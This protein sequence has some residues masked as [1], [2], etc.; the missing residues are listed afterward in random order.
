MNSEGIIDTNGTTFMFLVPSFFAAIF[1]AILS[2]V[3][4]SGT[5]FTTAS[6]TTITYNQLKEVNR[7]ATMQGGYQ[8]AGWLISIGIGGFAGL[9]L[10]V[11]YRGLDERSSAGEFFSDFYF[12]SKA[13]LN[14]DV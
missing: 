10:G 11:I 2:A 14:Y 13:K 4:Q 12:F 1:S 6:G 7:T 8:M 9:V 5:S 3:G